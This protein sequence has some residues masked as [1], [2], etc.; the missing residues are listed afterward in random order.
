MPS[1]VRSR[2][3]EGTSKFTLS[4]YHARLQSLLRD[5]ILSG[6]MEQSYIFFIIRWVLDPIIPIV[7]HRAPEASSAYVGPR[8]RMNE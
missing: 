6:L 8:G 3:F 5:P 1:Y 4:R 2:K 7:L